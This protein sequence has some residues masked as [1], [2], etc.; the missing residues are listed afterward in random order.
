VMCRVLEFVE[1]VEEREFSERI[2]LT[3]SQKGEGPTDKVYLRS[4]LYG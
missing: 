4:V 3:F 2:D 1:G